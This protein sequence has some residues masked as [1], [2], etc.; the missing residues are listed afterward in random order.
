MNLSHLGVCTAIIAASFTTSVWSIDTQTV[1]VSAKAVGGTA[2]LIT[3]KA[4]PMD[5]GMM[6][7]AAVA[8]MDIPTSPEAGTKGM[9]GP[10]V[11]WPIIPIHLALLPNGRVLSFGTGETGLQ[12]AMVH[13]IWSPTLGTGTSAHTVLPNTVSTDIFCAGQTVISSTGKTLITGGDATVNSIRNYSVAD[14]NF[15]DYQTGEMLSGTPMA[16][17]RW[18]PTLV[19]LA[20]GGVAI[21]GGRDEKEVPTYASTPELYTPGVGFRTLPWAVNGNAY[22][23]YGGSW[24]YPRGFLAPNGK[25]F[26][27]THTGH[28]FWMD[29]TGNGSIAELN[30]I[31]APLGHRGLPSLMYAPG[32]ILSVRSDKRVVVFDLNGPDVKMKEV[33]SLSHK[34]LI[35]S[36][37]V[38]A[39]GKV[40]VNGGSEVYNR[41][42]G[43]AYHTEIWNPATERWTRAAS[44][45][46]PRLY[47][48]NALLLPDG[49]VL[50]GGGGAPGPVKNLNAE[51]YYPP[52]LYK[53]DGS[54]APANR[55]SIN[56]AP[57]RLAWN[58]AFNVSFT[59][60]TPVSHVTF[61]RSGSA[62]HA[63]NVD[64]RFIKLAFT[65]V[66][67]ATIRV[68]SPKDRNNAPPG[69][70]MLF[71]IDQ[72]GV[73][74]ESRLIHLQ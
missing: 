7:S 71:I 8:A 16:F 42:Q 22:G 15:Y 74:S 52:Y 35:S 26:I 58:Q 5:F 36:A 45:N 72:N 64:Q 46:K 34:R 54:G 43:V 18:Y 68:T 62:T 17:K 53:H 51:I 30:N 28:A 31:K 6:G 47:H 41:L 33:A 65:R 44:A 23:K 73:P 12:G 57:E 69:H 21:L 39:D 3:E 60:S 56:I 37:T 11:N 61:V 19:A 4:D 38:L 55:P 20:N 24:Y 1:L 50:T 63:L 27:I 9:F 29:P 2:S 70:Y 13:D 49:T 48:S 32:K 25:V 67:A 40:F 14:T 66:D 10:P 59:S